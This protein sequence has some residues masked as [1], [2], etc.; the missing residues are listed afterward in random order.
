MS[1]WSAGFPCPLSWSGVPPSGLRGGL[2][3]FGSRPGSSISSSVFPFEPRL[4]EPVIWSS[5]VGACVGADLPR[6]RRDALGVEMR[7][8]GHMTTPQTTQM[9]LSEARATLETMTTAPESLPFDDRSTSASHPAPA[10]TW[11]EPDETTGSYALEARGA[12]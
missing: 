6:N 4:V 2:S 3:P 9:P 7:C 8:T 1:G 5:S 10:D 12:L 11:D